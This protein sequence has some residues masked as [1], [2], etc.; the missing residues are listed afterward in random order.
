M[1]TDLIII[2]SGPGGYE[3]AAYAAKNGLQVTIVEEKF[4]GGTCLNCGCIPTKALVHDAEEAVGKPDGAARFAAAIE[5]KNAIVAQ[6]RQGVEMLMGQP[7][8]QFVHGHGALKDAHTVVVGDEELTADNIII[9]T[10]STAKLPPVPGLGADGGEISP[11]VVTSEQLLDRTT[12]PS[13]LCIIGAGVIG[14]E[15]AS[16][17]SSFGTEV[18]VVEFFKECLPP[19]DSEISR[20]LRKL[21]EKQGVKFHLG[22]A[23]QRVEGQKVV[24]SNLKNNKEETVEADTVLVATGRQPRVNGLNLEAVGVKTDRK[25]IATDDNLMT[26]VPNVYAIGD[27]NG[28]QMLAHAATFQGY[29]VVNHILGKP[30]N[31][32]LDIMPSAIFTRPEAASVG[33]TED[34]CKE[35]GI[36]YTTQKAIYRANGRA[37]AMEQTEGLVKLIFDAHDKIIGCHA[38]GA[39]ASAMVQE[40]AALMNLDITRQRLADIIHIH[41]TLS[42]ILLDAV[43]H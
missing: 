24:F 43:K 41:P 12:L 18:T 32:R 13:S 37:Q 30:D 31:I 27:V 19:M 25:G 28:R 36:E 11:S 34:I 3:T 7:G 4:A 10:G 6:L 22:C 16:V 9:A 26:S 2:G 38:Y 35:Q 20:R 40:V 1:K 8:I 17:L 33:L 21:M 14:M 39:D 23:V 42:E 5:R 29:R 15:M